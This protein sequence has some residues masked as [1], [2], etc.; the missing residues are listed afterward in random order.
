MDLE[1]AASL[2]P[3]LGTPLHPWLS[4]GFESLDKV[5]LWFKYLKLFFFFLKSFMVRS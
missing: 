4:I 5:Y 2:A 1:K 3:S